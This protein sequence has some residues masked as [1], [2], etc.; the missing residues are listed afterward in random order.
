M[1]GNENM[2]SQNRLPCKTN[3]KKSNKCVLKNENRTN[4]EQTNKEE[5]NHGLG[6]INRTAVSF[7]L[8][9]FTKQSKTKL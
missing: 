3:G 7:T 2:K 5:W 9:Y 6:K 8:H 1:C 4:I